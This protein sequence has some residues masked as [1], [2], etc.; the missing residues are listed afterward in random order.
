MEAKNHAYN[1]YLYYS[2]GERALLKRIADS[3]QSLS[4]NNEEIEKLLIKYKYKYEGED[5]TVLSN[6]N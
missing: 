2:Q 6:R 5:S 4:I 3:E 1:A